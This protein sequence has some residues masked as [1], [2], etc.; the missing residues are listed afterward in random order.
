MLLVTHIHERCNIKDKWG[1]HTATSVPFLAAKGQ[2]HW[3]CPAPHC[4]SPAVGNVCKASLLPLWH[5][6]CSDDSI[7][8]LLSLDGGQSVVFPEC[9]F[10][11]VKWF[12][13]IGVFLKLGEKKSPGDTVKSQLRDEHEGRTTGWQGLYDGVGH[14]RSW[15]ENLDEVL[16]LFCWFFSLILLQ[17]RQK[18][19][20]LWII[21]RQG[22]NGMLY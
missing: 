1:D 19:Q 9:Y 2:S 4:H 17:S 16:L 20:A 12:L 14:Q 15:L 13:V 22:F 6:G 18:Q 21:L 3:L 11:W 8:R 10:N 7:M 5:S